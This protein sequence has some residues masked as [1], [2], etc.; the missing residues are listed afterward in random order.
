[1]TSINYLECILEFSWASSLFTA[2]RHAALLEVIKLK[3][4][5]D[6]E[7]D[8]FWIQKQSYTSLDFNLSGPLPLRPQ[9][10]QFVLP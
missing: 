2:S 6:L 9:P 4:I 10:H 3:T 7:I 5:T 8:N 1:M